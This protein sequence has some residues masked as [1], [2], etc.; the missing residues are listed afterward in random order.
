MV[1]VGCSSRSSRRVHVD[2]V[3]SSGRRPQRGALESFT[4]CVVVRGPGRCPVMGD[5]ECFEVGVE[6]GAELGSV[7]GQDTGHPD[8]ET[9]Q[10]GDHPV[11]EPFRD[12]SVGRAEEHFADRPAGRGIDRG[13][14]PDLPD[15]SSC[16]CRS[17]PTR[18]GHRAGRRSDRTRTVP[19]AHRRRPDQWLPRSAAPTPPRVHDA[20]PGRDGAG[21]SAHHW[22]RSRTLAWPS[23]A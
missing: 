11:E 9:T 4:H 20:G 21:S 13:E 17:C 5:L 12:L 14:L 6:R 10:F 2:V 23:R 8:P 19:P 22:P 3:L 16:R 7:V 15:A 1:V 18:P